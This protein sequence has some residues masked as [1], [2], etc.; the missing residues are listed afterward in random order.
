MSSRYSQQFADSAAV[1]LEDQG[2]TVTRYPKGD[3]GTP[4]SVT[5]IFEVRPADR[6]RRRGDETVMPAV[7]KV[8]PDETLDPNDIWEIGG[9]RYA[10]GP[11]SASDGLVEIEVKR[12]EKRHTKPDGT[13]VF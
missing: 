2:E 4:V 3:I 12:T 11:I 1:L 13:D 10:T 9:D 8:S 5:A 7:L 6:E